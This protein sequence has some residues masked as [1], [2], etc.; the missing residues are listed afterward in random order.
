[1]LRV[2]AADCD[3]GIVE[4]V[5]LMA[6]DAAPI[7]LCAGVPVIVPVERLI[8]SPLGRLLAL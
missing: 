5:T 1:M 7:E 3:E 6:I 2:D 4:S 8:V